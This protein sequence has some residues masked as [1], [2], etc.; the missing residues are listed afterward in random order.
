MSIRVLLCGVLVSCASA[1]PSRVQSVTLPALALQRPDGQASSFHEALGD[2]VAVID[3]WATWCTACERERPKLAR[4][5]TAYRT[6]GLRVIGL[7]VGES[8]SVVS[9]YLTL[10]SLP[11]AIY[12]DPEFRVAD[13]LGDHELPTILVVDRKGRIVHRSSSLDAPTLSQVKALLAGSAPNGTW[14]P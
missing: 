9:A 2:C 8:P 14:T 3:L 5:D 11:Y 10:H 12:L 7:N 6:Q 1:G 4:L 13:A